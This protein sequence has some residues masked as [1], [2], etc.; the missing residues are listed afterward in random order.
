M[1]EIVPYLS[2]P[3][4]GP[5]S[6]APVAEIVNAVLYKLKSGVQWHM[7]P[8]T[9]LFSGEP[10]NYKTVFGHYRKWSKAGV[11]KECWIRL[12]SENRSKVDL[13]S[14]DF[15][16]SHTTALRGG[17]QV[18]YQGRKKRKTTN[19]L[20]LTDRQGLPLAMSESVAGNYND[21]HDIEVHA[22]EV[23]AT[24]DDAG[25]A[26][27]GLFVNGD[28]GF[29]SRG[30]RTACAKRGVVPNVPYNQRG[31]EV[32][33]DEPFD[34]KLYGERYSVE[35][36]FAWMDGFRSVLNRFDTTVSS[37]MG[38]NFL[39]FIVIAIKKFKKINNSR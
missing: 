22:E 17:E 31:K 18:E 38:F 1:T 3:G 39:A 30:F 5:S 12:L 26:T 34:E 23:F 11:W 2:P 35:R 33:R 32:D 6:R 28:S 10:L 37:W 15:D 7:L 21:L 9:E 20:Y 14:G 16:G 24:L 27:D 8:V 13:S 25:I 19:S 36:T 4:R 29:D